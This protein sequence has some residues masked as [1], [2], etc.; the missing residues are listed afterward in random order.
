MIPEELGKVE[1]RDRVA[2]EA[3]L[4]PACDADRACREDEGGVADLDD[5]MQVR[6]VHPLKAAY[7]SVM[8][9]VERYL[10]TKS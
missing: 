2:P 9:G 8:V 7:R 1:N 5:A 3:V 6:D 10:T 4:T